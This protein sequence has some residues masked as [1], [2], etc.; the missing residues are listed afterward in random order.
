V[1]RPLIRQVPQRLAVAVDPV[2]DEVPRLARAVHRRL[3]LA[4]LVTDGAGEVAGVAGH[5]DRV[6][7]G[8]ATEEIVPSA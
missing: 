3:L 2:D 5:F 8:A 6:A 4:A 7:L 1:K